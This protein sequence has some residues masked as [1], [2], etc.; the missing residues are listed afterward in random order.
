MRLPA[1]LGLCLALTTTAGCSLFPD[2]RY[3][4]EGLGTELNWDGMAAATSLQ[5]RY[6]G[7]LCRQAGLSVAPDSK[8]AACIER[9]A[10]PADWSL[11]VQAGM[12]DIDLRCDAYLAWL[13][14]RRRSARPLLQQVSD[15]RSAAGTILDVTG[16]GP[17]PI[18]IASTALGLA[19]S[20]FANVNSRLLLEVNQ[21]TV[22]SLVL[23]RRNAY[24]LEIARVSIGSRPAAIHALRSYLNICMPFTIETEINTTVTAY[25]KGGTSALDVPPLISP[26]T[27]APSAP[28]PARQ[29]VDRA[30][31]PKPAVTPAYAEIIDGYNPAVHTPAYVARILDALCAPSTEARRPGPVTKGLIGIF[32]AS[33]RPS[34]GPR[35]RNGKLDDNEIGEILGQGSCKASAGR[36][37]FERR[38]FTNDA[39]GLAALSGLIAKLQ[40]HPAGGALP[41]SSSLAQARS[42]IAGVREEAQVK[43]QLRLSLPKQLSDHVT[44]DLF[45]VVMSTP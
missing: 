16:V 20:T 36:N 5:D 27:I 13:D 45:A 40:K 28:T 6:L 15:V 34:S 1:M 7:L 24:R 22:Q 33:Y 39:S 41:A 19:A 42:A 23:N 30:A 29:P 37:Y 17:H 10:T 11:L 25:E 3:V 35:R 18:T 12:N 8:A 26:D 43:S 32:E 31:Q 2:S 21:S 14:D 44:D 9:P 4:R 38:T